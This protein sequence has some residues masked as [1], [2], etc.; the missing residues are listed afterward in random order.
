[1]SAVSIPVPEFES[2]TPALERHIQAAIAATT[3][4]PPPI[5]RCRFQ[6]GCLS[7]LADQ[8]QVA[9]TT[10]AQITQFRVLIRAI[11]ASLAKFSALTEGVSASAG[12]LPVQVYLRQQG[13]QHPYAARK[14]EWQRPQASPA[15]APATGTELPAA[16]PQT[17]PPHPPGTLVLLPPPELPPASVLEE[18]AIPCTHQIPVDTP[19]QQS[20]QPVL[21][22]WRNWPVRSA[23]GLVALGLTIGSIAYGI[24]RPCLLGSCDRRQTAA[25]LSD[26]ALGQLPVTPT[27]AEIAQAHQDLQAA[28]NLLSGIPPWSPHHSAVQTDLHDYRAQLQEVDW[29]M[30]AQKHAIAAAEMSQDPP[31]PIPRWVDVH[32]RWQKALTVLRRIPNDS[33]LAGFAQRKLTEY[34]ANYQAIGHRLIIEEQAEVSL[35]AALQAGQLAANQTAQATTPST[36]LLAQRQ[37]QEAIQTLTQIPQG[38][39]AY[40][41]ARSQLQEYRLQLAHVRTYLNREKAGQRAYEA[42]LARAAAAQSAEQDQEWLLATQQWQRAQMH[43]AQVPENTAYYSEAQHYLRT[44][45]TALQQA[46]Q[47]ARQAVVLQRID[48][49]LTALC[50][51][52]GGICTV[53]QGPQ[54]IIILLNQPYDQA[55]RQSIS[56]PSTQASGA[57][58]AAVVAQT[59][60]LVQRIMQIGN[61]IQLPITLYTTDRQFIAQYKPEYGGF[62]QELP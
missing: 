19:W 26:S 43:M 61:Q 41:E 12:K 48:A 10:H 33:S 39:M 32:L 15:E 58:T 6:S 1:M 45:R 54:Q 21:Q 3:N 62:S 38:T 5:I 7:V 17:S 56:P 11:D 55:I 24:S 57:Q 53:T 27:P 51:T 36:W 44:Y 8:A 50:P 16:V 18:G 47:G 28:V 2:L 29:F 40:Q 22:S 13:A 59:H 25:N 20:W 46:E 60:Q 52:D 34:E 9:T 35:N 4:T 49:D 14:R 42:G 30:T 23:L 31:H 37:W